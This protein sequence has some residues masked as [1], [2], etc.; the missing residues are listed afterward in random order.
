MARTT[1]D[2]SGDAIGQAA[3]RVRD[4]AAEVSQ[5]LKDAAT[6]K[7]TEVKDRA[8]NAYN[9]G[10]ETAEQWEQSLESYVQEKPLQAVLLAAGVGLLLGL[11]WKRR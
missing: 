8:T 7:Y 11:L 6:D 9:Q 4:K 5:H 3:D 2:E 10:R 1:V